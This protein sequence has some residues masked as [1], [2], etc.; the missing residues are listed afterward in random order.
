V[1]WAVSGGTAAVERALVSIGD[2]CYIGPNVII[3]KGVTIGNGCIIGANSFVNTDIPS[4]MKAWGTPARIIKMTE[5]N[6]KN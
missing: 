5:E 1:N 6:K 2:R 3:S 4:G